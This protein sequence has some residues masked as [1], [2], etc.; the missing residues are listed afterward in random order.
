MSKNGHFLKFPQDYP[1]VPFQHFL[2]LVHFPKMSVFFSFFVVVCL[3]FISANR[4]KRGQNTGFETRNQSKSTQYRTVA[5]ICFNKAQKHPLSIQNGQICAR[6]QSVTVTRHRIEI[7]RWISMV[8]G[9][10]VASDP[11]C[12]REL[13]WIRSRNLAQNRS[14]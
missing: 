6:D 4:L 1:Q 5:Q 12:F 3:F 14:F 2:K 10:I 13:D 9:D 7:Y 11:P 8:S